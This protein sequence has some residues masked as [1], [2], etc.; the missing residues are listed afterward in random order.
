VD[1]LSGRYRGQTP[2]KEVSIKIPATISKTMA[3]VPEIRLVKYKTAM[4]KAASILTILSAV[5]MFNFIVPI[6]KWF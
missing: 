6:F 3:V 4:A 1:I 2:I 5:P